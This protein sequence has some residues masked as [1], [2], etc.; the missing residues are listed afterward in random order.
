MNDKVLC[1]KQDLVT[2]ANAV[3]EAADIT[4]NFNVPSLVEKTCEMLREGTKLPALTNPGKTS[5]ALSGKEF[6]D[7]DGNKVTGTIATKTASNLTASGSTV[8]VPAGYYASQATK[9]VAIATQA[10]PSVSIDS[11]GKITATATQTAGYVAAGTKTGTKQMTVQAAKTITPSTSSQTAVAKNV[12]TT[13]AVTVAA[14]PSEYVIPS[15]SLEITENG[16][17][18][19]T[20]YASAEINIASSG[21]GFPNGTEWTHVT[22]LNS[23]IRCIYNANG[24]C[25]VGTTTGLL[26]SY[27]GKIW[28]SS[29]VNSRIDT[30]Y[31]ANGLWVAGGTD[32]LYYS[33]NGTNWTKSSVSTDTKS[34][35]YGNGIWVAAANNT[36]DYTQY[37]TDGK[38]WIKS[39]FHISGHTVIC[40]NGLFILLSGN[41]T[42]G[43]IYYS[44]NGANWTRSNL[45]YATSYIAYGNGTFVAY[46]T[47]ESLYYSSDGKIWTKSA[48]STKYF[49]RTD[50]SIT[51]ANGIW[52]TIGTHGSLY[53]SNG[54][55]WTINSNDNLYGTSKIYYANGIW[56]RGHIR[57]LL[58][59]YDGKN[60]TQSLSTE[61]SAYWWVIANYNGIWIAG[62]SKGIYYSV[63][64]EPSA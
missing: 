27:D 60:W 25:V 48:L 31:N 38:N 55:N 23:N 7:G 53:S 39:D 62:N 1:E 26:Y 29:N 5:D 36:G 64:W 57:G 49:N 50:V 10:T 33:S 37:S 44:S 18:D 32:G 16:T 21:G 19:V 56:I 58:Y 22:S 63:T 6:I 11:A 52:I 8:T 34:V 35:V 2:I 45:T 9:S 42:N 43:G 24:L 17:H 4:D 47:G 59:S 12:Y 20:N 30:V 51:Y 61:S 40:E 14:I 15:G 46:A 54:K 13:G 28:A 41:S 3:R